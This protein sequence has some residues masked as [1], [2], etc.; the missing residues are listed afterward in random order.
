[1]AVTI[2]FLDM[3]DYVIEAAYGGVFFVVMITFMPLRSFV[4]LPDWFPV[5]RANA[6]AVSLKGLNLILHILAFVLCSFVSMSVFFPNDPGNFLALAGFVAYILVFHGGRWT[7]KLTAVL[8]VFPA[9]AAVNFLMMD[10]GRRLFFSL[11]GAP[12]SSREGWTQTQWFISTVIYTLSQLFRL[13]FWIVAWRILRKHLQRITANLTTKMWLTLDALMLTPFV[14]VIIAIC[15]MPENPI[16]SYPIC[17]ASVLSSFECICLTSYICG[18]MQTAYHA[19]ELEMKQEYYQD[20]INDEEQVRSIYHDLKNH[21]L[22]LQAQTDKAQ[23]LQM[24]VQELENRV[25]DYENYY[26]TGNEFLDI[27]FRDKARAAREKG[28]DFS[29]VISF[30]DGAFMEPLD[31][32]TIFGNA[33]DNAIE[34]AERLPEEQ[35]LITVK[36]NRIHNM[37]MIIVENN[38]APGYGVPERTSKKDTFLHGFGLANI[39]NTAEKYGG[40]CSTKAEDDRFVLKVMIPVP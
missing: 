2:K 36:T 37:L 6:A 22:I 32:S 21:L 1:M 31:I 3:F 12:G 34:A 13:L 33:L 38:V 26:H 27:I 9:F 20:R 23:E 8:V 17:I 19:Q 30:E 5:R 4:K 25:R 11:T 14:S 7:E 39:R 18:S 10:V 15:F 40:S 29:A 24:S 16:L 35:R 28:I